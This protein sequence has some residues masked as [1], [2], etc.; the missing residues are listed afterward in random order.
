M[1]ATLQGL[2]ASKEFC[3]Y[4]WKLEIRLPGDEIQLRTLSAIVNLSKWA[5][6]GD[7]GDDLDMKGILRFFG[8]A[9][10]EDRLKFDSDT[11]HD[12]HEFVEKML[13]AL[14]KD[15]LEYVDDKLDICKDL[16]M[17]TSTFLPSIC[18]R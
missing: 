18:T 1:N 3:D 17:L 4:L 8:E 11:Q 9:F 12:A 16:F 2:F 7:L 6:Q 5:N 15:V 14:Q 10:A 13:E